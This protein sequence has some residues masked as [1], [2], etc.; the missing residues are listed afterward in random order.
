MY[1][2]I[3]CRIRLSALMAVTKVGNRVCDR[4]DQDPGILITMEVLHGWFPIFESLH[5]AVEKL[6]GRLQLHIGAHLNP[7]GYAARA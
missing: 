3:V 2:L 1:A 4:G 5:Q 7:R 6:D